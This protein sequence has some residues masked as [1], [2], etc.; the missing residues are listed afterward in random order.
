MRFAYIALH[1]SSSCRRKKRPNLEMIFR[2]LF[3]PNPRGVPGSDISRVWESDG[4]AVSLT[5]LEG[6]WRGE[7]VAESNSG[8][9]YRTVGILCSLEGG[10]VLE[11]GIWKEC[12]PGA[13]KQW[14]GP[15]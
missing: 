14:A 4:L 15:A 6:R 3:R 5:R 7:G 1:P 12:P 2:S 8:S 11:G 9:G 13:Q 10:C